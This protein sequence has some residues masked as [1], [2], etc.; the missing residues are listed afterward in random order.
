MNKKRVRWALT[1][2]VLCAL[3]VGLISAMSLVEADMPLQS[4]NQW[5]RD[6]N[7]T[8][9]AYPGQ[10]TR[11][12]TTDIS[13]VRVVR[14]GQ[15][16]SV[17]EK[18]GIPTRIDADS[19][20]YVGTTGDVI[21]DG[22]VIMMHGNQ[23]L[24]APRIVGNT[25]ST[26]YHTAG[27]NFKYSETGPD[28]K[29]M[30]GGE[31]TYRSN[32][33]YM[34]ADQVQG[35]AT[36]YYFKGTHAVFQ[37]GVGHIEKGMIT[38]KNAMA[39]VHTPDYRVEGKDITV[40]PGD[41]VVINHP[42]FYIK[43]T[44]LFSLPS[45]TKS[46]RHD[47]EGQFSL[48]SLMPRPMYDSDDG[49]GLQGELTFPSGKDGEWYANYQIFQKVGFKPNIGSR[50]QFPWGPASLGYSKE[51]ATLWDEKVWVEKIGELRVD[52]NIYHIANSPITIHGGANIGYWKESNIKGMHNEV[53][54]ELSHNT[55]HPWKGANLRFYTGYQRDYYAY[56]SKVRSM[57]Y[58]GV[59]LN[60]Q[61]GKKLDAWIGYTNRNIKTNNSPYPFDT[62]DIPKNLHYGLNWHATRLDDFGISFQQNMD[63][64]KLEYRD[65]TYHRDMHSFDAYLTYKSIQ[66]NWEFKLKARDF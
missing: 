46:L 14:R 23:E 45:Y 52:S 59:E 5:Q 29:N 27:G 34:S 9:E 56:N 17:I 13:T 7:H 2:G 16:E 37:N 24:R 42:S 6:I 36:P 44:K 19:M 47:G 53:Y 57:P 32:D 11:T 61:V 41:K 40:Y 3:Q 8:N 4:E 12:N 1:A 65:Y 60:S 63:T 26:E 22:N 18:E 58:Y 64:G 50:R 31:L 55:I 21:A 48:F 28:A 66:K 35:F 10:L 25:N 54:V 49:I 33:N 20:S 43:N 39:F 38:T 62:V 51:D 30:S 15:A